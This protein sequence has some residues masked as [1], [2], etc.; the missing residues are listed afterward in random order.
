MLSCQSLHT[1]KRLDELNHFSL[2]MQAL[3]ET[4]VLERLLDSWA[5]MYISPLKFT[6]WH[7]DK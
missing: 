7:L 4:L 3:P 6:Y 1:A 2:A 5:L